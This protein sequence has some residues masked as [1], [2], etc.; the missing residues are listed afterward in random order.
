MA[1]EPTIF[2][3]DDDGAVCDALGVLLELEGY[4]V[5]TF[6]S[7]L[8]FLASRATL[9]ADD[10]CLLLDVSMPEID[11]LELQRRLRAAGSALPVVFMTAHADVPIAIRAMKE[12][13]ADFIEK[14]FTDNRL[15][16]AVTQAMSRSG[17][18]P[19]RRSEP[20]GSAEAQEQVARLTRRERE[21]LERLVAGRP[22]KVI[23][24]ELGM[25]PRTVEKHRARVMEKLGARS[26]SQ[27]VRTALAAGI[28][29][30]S[31]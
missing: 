22:N 11:G 1:A 19:A 25:S 21:V 12:G 7:G 23:A 15:R 6:T 18:P 5:E 3:V 30:S 29:V 9:E 8:V 10:G 16:E 2:V 31:A 4:R 20:A 13:A 26:L 24:F 28:D 14:P 27:V 17:P